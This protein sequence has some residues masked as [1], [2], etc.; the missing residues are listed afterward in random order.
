MNREAC[1]I[2]LTRGQGNQL[3]IYLALRSLKLAFLGGFHAF[4]GGGVS[5]VD[6]QV[7]V[8][9]ASQ[10]LPA[11]IVSCA[12]RELLE[13]CGIVVAGKLASDPAAREAARQ[14]LL[15]DIAVWPEMVGRGDVLLDARQFN[16]FGRWVTPPFGPMRFDAQYLHLEADALDPVIWPGEL[17][18][19]MWL[20]PSSAL[21]MHDA[22]RIYISYPV[23]ETTRTIQTAHNDMAVAARAMEARGVHMP[24]GGEMLTGVQVLPLESPTIAPA[25]HTNVYVLGHH[26]VVIVDPAPTAEKPREELIH[27]LTR[28]Q[29]SGVRLREVWLTHHH[30]DHVG[31]ANLVREHFK[32]PVAAHELTAREL[33]GTVAVDR[34]IADG[35][36]TRMPLIGDHY[37]E[38]TAVLTPGHARGHLCFFDTRMRTLLSGD[39][40][41][42]LGTIIVAPPDGDMRDYM[43]SLAR[44]RALNPRL[45]FPSH[46]PPVG[47]LAKIDEY[48]AHRLAR[49]NAILEALRTVSTAHDVVP[50]VYTDVPKHVWPLAEVNVQAH[51]DKLEAEGRVRRSG[52]SYLLG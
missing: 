48:I 51:L 5:K 41:A 50:L 35:D 27:Y 36:V 11:H 9:N 46:G 7:S 34:L 14:A 22:G 2:V 28:M 45:L 19:G 38:W 43:A 4:P 10:A 30:P 17:D 25:T 44:V 6:R 39:L 42:S 13:E 26:D 18:E 32:I 40:L 47:A 49:E 16:A 20:T 12:A 21:A 31:A 23:L 33:R 15:D 37:A 3:S 8:A 52:Q 24:A 29:A 1:A